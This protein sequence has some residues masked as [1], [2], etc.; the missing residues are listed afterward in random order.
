MKMRQEREQAEK[1]FNEKEF[2]VGVW[3]FFFENRRLKIVNL[4]FLYKNSRIRS[5]EFHKKKFTN[6]FKVQLNSTKSSKN[7]T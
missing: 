3:I 5:F 7:S 4:N 2:P 6:V 1:I